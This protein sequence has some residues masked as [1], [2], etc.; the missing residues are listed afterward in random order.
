MPR[1]HPAYRLHKARNSAVVTLD[2]KDHYL[3][4]HNSPESW[5][6]YHRLVA[7]WLADGGA[8][9]PARAEAVTSS[10]TISEVILAYWGFVKS[11]YVKD[12]KPTSERDTIHQA[13]RFVRRLYGSTAANDFSPK[14]LKVV[15]QAM[16]DHPIT[17]TVKVRN[18]A[19]GQVQE[20]T[21][22]I[23]LGLARKFINKQV[24]RIRRMFAWAVEEEL[25]P[26][27]VHQALLRVTSL[28]RGKSNAREKP[29]I[30]PVP[31]GHVEA[32][33]TLVSPAVRTMIEVQLL[34]GGRPQDIVHM[35]AVDIDRSTS[36][37]EY[38]PGR[39][40]TEHRNDDDVPDK[41]RVVYLGPRAQELLTPYLNGDPQSY[42]FSPRRS[43]EQRSAERRRQ[44]RTP[45]WPCHVRRQN[46]KRQRHGPP[47]WRERYS[48]DSYRKAIRRACLK[49]GIPIWHPNQLRHSRL[50]QIRK[51]YGL[52][53]SK[54]CAGHSE[55]GVTQH[56]AEQDSALAHKVMA[57]IG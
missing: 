8:N 40:K 24:A 52:E 51:H 32:V 31:D 6:K 25:V 13:L 34:C 30:L 15:R 10:P 3:G 29:R 14:A 41:D 46:H 43:E 20:L 7:E 11:Y 28:K 39:N 23:H 36:I 54:V 57:E 16:I 9:L 45:L 4:P 17:R 38:H 27:T 12:G 26:V 48:D 42:L 56:Y 33:L 53:A 22:V 55:I 35:R 21:K 19:T 50:T 37:W 49:A 18:K 47:R 44:R 2:G 1:R 5:E